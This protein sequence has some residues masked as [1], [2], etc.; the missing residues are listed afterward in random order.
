M[1]IHAKIVFVF[2]WFVGCMH[3]II[4]IFVIHQDSLVPEGMSRFSILPSGPCA[5]FVDPDTFLM[6]FKFFS[7]LFNYF[8]ILRWMQPQII[9][10]SLDP[11]RAKKIF[12]KK[13][14]GHTAV[15]AI[16]ASSVTL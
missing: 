14:L 15:S 1:I 10:K 7:L 3:R 13:K 4:M 12:I 6:G 2:Q 8:F 9:M 16:K 5:S 11:L